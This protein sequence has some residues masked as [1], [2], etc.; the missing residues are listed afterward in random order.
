MYIAVTSIQKKKKRKRKKEREQEEE[1]GTIVAWVRGCKHTPGNITRVR[2]SLTMK[3]PKIGFGLNWLPGV[4]DTT[5]NY[6]SARVPKK[7]GIRH[8]EG[9]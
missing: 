7:R 9:K 2:V 5:I 6:V 3:F 1:A 8:K 4:P